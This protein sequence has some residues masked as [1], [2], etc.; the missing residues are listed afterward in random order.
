MKNTINCFF[1]L[2]FL[3]INSCAITKTVNI[4]EPYIKIYSNL[5]GSK[6]DLFVRANIWFVTTFNDAKSV[7]QFSDKEKGVILGKFILHPGITETE[8]N[9]V[10]EIRVKDEKAKIS[11]VT[12]SWKYD[13]SGSSL[14]RYSVENAVND[15]QYFCISFQEAMNKKEI[16]F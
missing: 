12:N 16:D 14:Y 5:P 11:I 9:A 13:K 6:N 3:V 2:S 1:I 15:I 7:I 10:I 8:V 4:D